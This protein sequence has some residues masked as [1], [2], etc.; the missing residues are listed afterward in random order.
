[1]N[2]LFMITLMLLLMLSASANAQV[3]TDFT[4]SAVRELPVCNCASVDSQII[5]KNIGTIP[6]VF[7]VTQEGDTQFITAFPGVF[8]L[9]AGE[10]KVISEMINVPC[11]SIGTYKVKTNIKSDLNIHKSLEQT[12][13][14]K[15]CSNTE[16]ATDAAYKSICSCEHD[17]FDFTVENIG[18]FTDTYTFSVDRQEEYLSVTPFGA[19]MAPGKS[20]DVSVETDFPCNKKGTKEFNFVSYSENNK[21]RAVVPMSIF[22]NNSCYLNATD[23]STIKWPVVTAELLMQVL[24]VVL[25]IFIIFLI[26]IILLVFL[27]K[28]PE[29]VEETPQVAIVSKKPAKEKS[30]KWESEFP[31]DEDE[32]ENKDFS[33]QI[34]LTLAL[35]VAILVISAVIA[36][37]YIAPGLIG[38][39]E[40]QQNVSEAN[41]TSDSFFDT[42]F[43]KNLFAGKDDKNITEE[44]EGEDE[45]VVIVPVKKP[46]DNL[47]DDPVRSS[48]G[49]PAP[50]NETIENES[51]F[52]MTASMDKAKDWC[53]ENKTP[54]YIVLGVIAALILIGIIV[55]FVLKY[56]NSRK[57]R[58]EPYYK[59]LSSSKVKESAFKK[60]FFKF[61]PYIVAAIIV[62]ILI[63][64]FREQIFSLT[65]FESIKNFILDYY[66]YMIIGLILLAVIIIFLHFFEK[67]KSK[68]EEVK[69]KKKKSGR[70]K[71]R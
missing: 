34:W 23:T 4:A 71:K 67:G 39:N 3:F 50:R 5:V 48:K 57:K 31:K 16:I 28:K 63:I 42:S 30:F 66:M 47:K 10:T 19:T 13:N 27:R 24:A 17:S 33:F 62:I 37:P 18:S 45:P 11:D 38:D 53:K 65:I 61:I 59:R 15:R 26:I 1:M 44:P 43:F 55:F 22:L 9:E 58:G 32:K 54:I 7:T 41:E 49:T 25:A 20:I 69:P 29:T 64:I 70:K 35:I 14:V 56:L 21:E 2:K 8:M 68:K 40:T 51:K 52:N 6:S 12:I 36:L 60:H 46:K